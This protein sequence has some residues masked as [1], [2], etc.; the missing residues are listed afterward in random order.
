MGWLCLELD[1]SPRG[2]E[3]MWL[4]YSEETADVVRGE[5]RGVQSANKK[6]ESGGEHNI[7][8]SEEE[9]ARHP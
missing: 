1:F 6:L 5:A 9:E 7:V 3:K 8:W 2:M 4:V